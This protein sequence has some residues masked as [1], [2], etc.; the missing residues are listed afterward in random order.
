M[1]LS[2]FVSLSV[3]LILNVSLLQGAGLSY[4][5]FAFAWGAAA[6]GETHSVTVRNTA[7][8]AGA[9][10]VLGFVS[11]SS[12]TGFPIRRLFD[13]NR[14]RIIEPGGSESV[15]LRSP[16]SAFA[17]SNEAGISV[18]TPGEYILSTGDA[19]RLVTK[20]I[21]VPASDT[22][23]PTA[24]S[25]GGDSSG[26]ADLGWM[27]SYKAGYRD[28]QAQWAGGSEIMHIKSHKGKLFA[29]NG[30]WKDSHYTPQ[31]PGSSQSAQVLR[32]DE[33]NGTWQVDLDTMA[34]GRPTHMK[35]NIMHTVTFTTDSK[36]RPVDRT[37]LV[38]ASH[39]DSVSR[40]PGP[41][42]STAISFFIRHDDA[43][44]ARW[45]ATQ[46][47][48]GPTGGRKVPRD[49]EIHTDTVTNIARIFLLCGDSGVIS[50][51]WDEDQQTIIWDEHTEYPGPGKK[52]PVR[53]LGMTEANGKLYF[54]VGGQIYVRTDGAA[55][56]WSLAFQIPGTVNTEVGGIR[57]LTTIPNPTQA[58][59]GKGGDSLI[60]VWTPN[61][62]SIGVVN[63][64]DGPELKQANETTLRELYATH[65]ASRAPP[66]H[67]F[68]P[69]SRALATPRTTADASVWCAQ[70][71]APSARR[72]TRSAATTRSSPCRHRAAER[73][74]TSSASSKPSS[75]ANPTCKRQQPG[76]LRPWSV[77]KHRTAMLKQVWCVRRMFGNYYAGQAEPLPAPRAL[78]VLRASLCGRQAA[79]TLCAADRPP[80]P[81]TRST[82]HSRLVSTTAF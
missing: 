80:T 9:T 37:L 79:A 1:M 31:T 60:F 63:R 66:L 48:P 43:S 26:G 69:H 46:L 70:W 32:L 23:P 64:L 4:S 74:S 15:V 54:S 40:G 21:H 55:P 7:G 39:S 56:Q 65:S 57:G 72:A 12:V 28:S 14:T 62:Q 5:T 44:P 34:E 33:P 8:P 13:F 19:G 61:G 50:G 18:V 81:P 58:A 29:F 49:I 52:F 77:G 30:Y 59:D 35:G 38:A 22:A 20:H 67:P 3:S 6:D 51:A 25:G 17:L 75:V 36:G 11:T 76:S 73:P 71:R 16:R 27:Q 24:S 53:A 82:V 2:R 47:L 42:P 78:L 45:S 41:Q 68:A 10:V